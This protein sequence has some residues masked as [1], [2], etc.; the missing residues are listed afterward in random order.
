MRFLDGIKHH[1]A[2]SKMDHSSSSSSSHYHNP[3][4]HSIPGNYQNNHNYNHNGMHLAG[5]GEYPSMGHPG[6]F[7]IPADGEEGLGGQ[8]PPGYFGS[9][10][11]S[12]ELPGMI[13]QFGPIGGGGKT[14]KKRGPKRGKGNDSNHPGIFSNKNSV[15]GNNQLY[16]DHQRQMLLLQQRT[17]AVDMDMMRR[18][19]QSQVT[20]QKQVD[21]DLF[22]HFLVIRI[23]STCVTIVIKNRVLIFLLL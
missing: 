7:H 13:H 4:T 2:S 11:G 10:A 3:K 19:Q 15:V 23:V 5:V 1:R 20:Y 12:E 14:G 21:L 16:L 8:Y 9:G 17:Q 22:Y 18:Q 6:G